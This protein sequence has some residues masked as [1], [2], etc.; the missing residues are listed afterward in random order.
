MNEF[1][2]ALSTVSAL[3]A[4]P[5]GR[6]VDEVAR[7][8]GLDPA[9]IIK[10][11][12]NENPLGCSPDVAHAISGM[13][14]QA[15]IYPDFAN[16]DLNRAIA[17]VNGLE[18]GQVLAGAGSSEI[19]L[20][21]V[22]AFL[23][24]SRTAIIP[25][26]SFQAYEGMVQSVGANKIIIP[27]KGWDFDL[28]AILEAVSEDTK[29]LFLTTPNNPTGVTIAPHILEDFIDRL[30]D[31]VLL[32]LD[33]AYREYLAPEDRIDIPALL[34]KR[35]NLLVLRTFSKIYGLAG[36]R[37]GYGLG[38]P[39]LLQLLRRLQMPFSVNSYAQSA[40][41][42]A[43]RDTDFLNKAYELN[44]S[45]LQRVSEALQSRGIEFVP[46]AGNFVLIKVGNGPMIAREMMKLGVI[47][48]PVSNYGL[49]EWVRVTIGLP[50]E[51]D[52]F[53][54]VLGEALSNV[55]TDS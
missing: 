26:Y 2:G 36:L 54:T 5:P 52:R 27:A 41:I 34:K 44:K 45:E 7:E 4:Y 22:R 15:N 6:P 50:G 1:T 17:E 28:E 42:A 40:A 20:M 14:S 11:A 30:P 35:R 29:L 25:Q 8:F 38:D 23:D 55:E 39:D 46:S 10:L 19:I 9:S 16:Y 3:P 48:R 37:V 12:S 49:P 51:N 13:A 47:V 53:L 31:H 24:S 21:A 43:L 33:E 32:V 18:P